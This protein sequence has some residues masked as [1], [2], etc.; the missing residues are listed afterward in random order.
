MNPDLTKSWHLNS[1]KWKSNLGSGGLP[2]WESLRSST[3]CTA[4]AEMS[5][6]DDKL[7]GHL[8]R[9]AKMLMMMMM[10]MMMIAITSGMSHL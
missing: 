7:K 5:S 10:M 8:M 9:T 4:P 3:V 2:A 6:L 1:D